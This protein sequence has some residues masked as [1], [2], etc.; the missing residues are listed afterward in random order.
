[1]IIVKLMGGLGNQMFQYAAGRR[2]A[3]R[4]NAELKLDLSHLGGN[5]DGITPR[6]FDLKHLNITAAIASPREMAEMCRP[7]PSRIEYLW[8]WLRQ[9]VGLKKTRPYLLREGQ[10]HFDPELLHAPDNVYME[11]YWQSERYFADISS[12]IRREFAC[13]APLAGAN[14]ELA[15]MI[16]G[17]NSVSIHVRRGD[18]VTSKAASEY[19]GVCSLDYYRSCI[20]ELAQ[21]VPG[22][23]LFVFSDEPGW[24]REQLKTGFPTTVVSH[25]GPEGAHEDLRLMSLCRHNINANS[26]FSWWGSWLNVNP[27]KMVFAPKLWFRD[28][29]RDTSDLIPQGWRR[30]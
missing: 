24:A 30:R 1:M 12:I 6:S 21:A 4:Y 14:L 7:V 20:D 2:L 16:T 27:E 11:G 26:S 22:L 18:Y 28:A 17:C 13:K 15:E 29:N 25:N 9:S 5:Q 19:H 10:F 3:Q 8:L 23:R